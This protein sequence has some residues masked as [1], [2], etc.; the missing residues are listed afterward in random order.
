MKAIFVRKALDLGELKILTKEAE[1]HDEEP[2]EYEVI[3][4]IKMSKV[5]FRDFVEDF[6]KIQH[7][8]DSNDGGVSS[9]FKIRCIRVINMDTGERI[10]VNSEGYNYARYTAIEK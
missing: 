10:L 4:E 2:I 9:E 6:S 5:A 8:I 3:K 7:W 1:K